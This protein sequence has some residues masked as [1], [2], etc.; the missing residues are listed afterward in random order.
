MKIPTELWKNWEG[1]IVGEKFPLKRHLGGSNDSAVFLTEH[2]R[3]TS[4]HAAIKLVAAENE[5][6]RLRRWGEGA[7][8]S[9]PH[10]IRIFDSGRCE[11]DGARL[12]YVV[13][14]YAEEN[15]AEILPLRALSPDEATLMLPPAVD[16]LE[17]LHQK[18]YAHGHIK[19]SN[20]MA[21]DNQLKISADG[22]GKSEDRGAVHSPGVYDAPETSS[23]GPSP[24]GDVWSLGRTLVAVMTQ[25]EPGLSNGP[26][27]VS[28]VPETIPHPLRE[29]VRD[30]LRADPQQ[31][32]PLRTIVNRLQP[33]VTPEEK[34]V[35]SVGPPVRAKRSMTAPIIVAALVLAAVVGIRIFAHRPQPTVVE[36]Q[37][38]SALRPSDSAAAKTAAPAIDAA[39]PTQ[40][41]TVRGAVLKQVMPN[42]SRNAQNT[43]SGRLKVSVQVSVDSG[44][45]VSEAK[46][47]SAGPSKY[48]ASRALEAAREWKFTPPQVN[49]QASNSEWMLRFQFGRKGIQASPAEINP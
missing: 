18:G 11:F 7:K 28:V 40:A 41:G 31:R 3:G 17:Y 38:Q 9:H 15:L 24:A 12:L 45:S 37:P 16:A 43:I 19:P 47:A 5:D 30:C 42:V 4:G 1:R 2:K 49:G 36:S 34:F 13:T 21:V 6:A 20:I 25:S 26:A 39:Q 46:L 27:P 14:E 44:G 32:P 48:F 23:A 8:L 22:I 29:I 33:R 35:D 10:L